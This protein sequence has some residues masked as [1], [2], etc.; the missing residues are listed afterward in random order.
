[1]DSQPEIDREKGEKGGEF[2]E[3]SRACSERPGMTMVAGFRRRAVRK[4]STIG[5]LE[6]VLACFVGLGR[7]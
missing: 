3:G 7:S 5:R 2:T 6:G 1:M 4:K